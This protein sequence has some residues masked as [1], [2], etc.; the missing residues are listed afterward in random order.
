MLVQPQVVNLVEKLMGLMFTHPRVV[1][2]LLLML[3]LILVLVMVD[4]L[5]Q[6][7]VTVDDYGIR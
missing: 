5:Q 6:R 2:L 4:D 3:L 1:V 7:W